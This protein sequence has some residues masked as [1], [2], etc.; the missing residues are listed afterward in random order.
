LI[1][2]FGRYKIGKGVEGGVGF[3]DGI[4]IHDKDTMGRKPVS[5]KIY[6]EIF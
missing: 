1:A 6:F 2:A 4:N 3:G 5:R